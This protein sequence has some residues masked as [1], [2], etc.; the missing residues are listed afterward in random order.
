MSEKPRMSGYGYIERYDWGK[1]K[2]GLW[3][4]DIGS[5]SFNYCK[6]IKCLNADEH[7]YAFD[8]QF[9]YLKEKHDRQI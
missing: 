2:V 8:G 5:R 6:D 3:Y 4:A 9:F 7:E 1:T